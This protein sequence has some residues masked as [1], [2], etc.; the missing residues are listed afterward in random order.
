MTVNSSQQTQ[1]DATWFQSQVLNWYDKH[2][3]K[4]LPWQQDVSPYKV[5]LSEVMLQ[6]TQVKTVIP[7]FESFMS[8][9]PTVVDLANA[10]EDEVLHLWTGLGYYARARNLHKAAKKV[11][12]EFAGVFP[13]EFDQ[14]LALP[15]IGRSTAGAILSLGDGQCHPILDGNVKRVLTRFFAVEGWPGKKAVENEL[16]LFAE[17]LT[18][19]TRPSNF[20]QVMMDLGATVCS[21][22]KPD[23]EACPLVDRCQAKA[24][25]RQTDFPFSKPKKEKPIKFCYMLML[26][27]SGKVQMYQ[28]PKQGI[29]GGLYSFPEFESL[30]EVEQTLNLLNIDLVDVDIDEGALFRHTFSHYHLDIQPITVAIADE[31]SIGFEIAEHNQIWLSVAP[32]QRPKVG[33]SA[34]AEKLLNEI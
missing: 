5:W 13:T 21:R 7:Y 27:K 15:G 20:N 4:H 26:V 29:W 9:F 32:E 33:L 24:L 8:R 18:S 25:D 28:R 34:V 19:K 12:D 14:V 16:W 30:D 3:R 10:D 23:C 11:R 17:Q 31:V 6:Q 1:V 2:G 22:S